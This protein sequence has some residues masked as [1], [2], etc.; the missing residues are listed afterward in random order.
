MD[1]LIIFK[2]K[3]KKQVVGL[4]YFMYFYKARITYFK[5]FHFIKS[6]F[7]NLEIK[8]ESIIINNNN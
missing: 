6:Y 3:L 1:I 4:T 5:T 7:N 8:K 2:V